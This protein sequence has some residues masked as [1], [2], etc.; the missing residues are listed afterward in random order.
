MEWGT[1]AV[2]LLTFCGVGVLWYWIHHDRSGAVSCCGCG[3][4][5]RAGE[6]VMVK[7]KSSKKGE[8]PA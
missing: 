3:Q 2:L 7:K 5:V 1:L 6:C 4:C 8:D